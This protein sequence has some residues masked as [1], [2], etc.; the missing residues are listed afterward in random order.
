MWTEPASAAGAQQSRRILALRVDFPIEEVDEP[1]TSGQGRFDLRS[2]ARALPDYRLPYDTPPHDRA[3][4]QYHLQALARYYATVSEGQVIVE[5]EVFP[6]QDTL[7]YTL[8]ASALSYGNGRSPEE[9]GRKWRQLAADAFALA[10]A[11]PAGPVF[12][13]YDS[14]LIIHAGLGHETGQLNDIR[15]VF[16]AAADLAAYGGPLSVGGGSHRIEDLWILPEAVDDRGR[17]GLNGLMAKFF[18]HQ[19]GLPGLSNFADGLPGV[20]GWSLMDV[21]ANRI[22]F[23]LHDNELDYVFGVVPP[24][25]LAWS[26][27]QLGWIEATMVR[28]DTTVTIAAGD[29]PLGPGSAA[30]RA[31]RVSLSPTESIWLENRQQRARTEFDLPAGVVVP[32]QG[33]EL[34]WI[35]PSAA[36][37]SHTITRAE[38][39]SLAGREAGVWLG[40]DEYDAFIPSA[41]ILAWHVDTAVMDGATDGFNNDRE[42]PGL[43]L[44]EA[45]GYRDIGN[46]YFDR[47]DLTE[48]TRADAFHAGV[49]ADGTPGVDRLGPET[50]PDTRTHT[51]LHSGVQIDVLSPPGDSMLVRVRFTRNTPG[52]PRRLAGARQVQAA[53][54]QEDQQIDLIAASASETV[55]FNNNGGADVRLTGSFLAAS[56][57]GLFVSTA[58]GIFAHEPDGSPRW[59]APGRPVEAALLASSLSATGAG[60]VVARG[61]G[62]TVH[63]PVSGEVIFEDNLPATA[64]GAADLDDDGDDDLIVVGPQGARKYDGSSSTAIGLGREQLLPPALGDLD[65]DG[66]ADVVLL[67]GNG[68]LTTVGQ[69]N[70]IEVLLGAAPTGAP[71]LADVDGDGTLEILVLTPGALHVITAGGLRA[72]GFPAAIPVYH[73]AGMF[74]DEPVSADIDGNGTQDVFAA[75]AIGV[76][77]FRTDGVLLP[78]FPVLTTAALT[79]APLLDDVDGDG[80]I[81]V[82][83]AADDAVY[84]WRPSSWN[85]AFGAGAALGWAQAAGSATGVRAHARLDDLPVAQAT[86]DLLPLLRAYCYPNPVDRAAGLATVRFYLTREARVTLRVYDAIGN[87]MNQVEAADLRSGAENEISWTVDTYASGLYLCRL[88]GH[89]TDGSKGDVTL[90]M[91][92]SR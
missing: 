42:R 63:N 10:E 92:V 56:A 91:A 6:E 1:T 40:T 2:L 27:A 23:I 80:A 31:V 34:G 24:H 55:V 85:D 35:D 59:A 54:L 71:S 75:T 51:G 62:L 11:D 32:F 28:S 22:G 25:P 47:Q 36:Q 86:G 50:S 16:L 53:D 61:T 67:D 37:F 17:A 13:E 74:L 60:L 14:Y 66:D 84:A 4:Y 76:Y 15:S 9:I 87:E 58:T 70:D 48:G 81:D 30:A 33:L 69:I 72:A 12:S 88:S 46:F 7:A 39:D 73:E 77:G 26:K 20:G 43:M 52:W 44:K 57:A 45:D 19:L 65:A 83:A 8:P 18:G 38:S 89:G 79:H 64:L 78:G 3:H 29:R 82:L 68:Q 21:G 49:A 5:G 90:R 41:G